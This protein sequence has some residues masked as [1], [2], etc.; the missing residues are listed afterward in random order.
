MAVLG[1][2]LTS[3]HIRLFTRICSRYVGGGSDAIPADKCRCGDTPGVAVTEI[4]YRT[5]LIVGA[6]SVRRR[7]RRARRRRDP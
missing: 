3:M 1:L 7:M 5:A 6:G 2:I 4:P